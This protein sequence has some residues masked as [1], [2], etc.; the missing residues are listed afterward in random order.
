MLVSGSMLVGVGGVVVVNG[1]VGVLVGVSVSAGVLVAVG[2]GGEVSAGVSVTDVGVDV[3][4]GA[5]G[6]SSITPGVFSVLQKKLVKNIVTR[7]S[8]R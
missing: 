5:G 8:G 6:V 7:L 1:A 3:L 4:I 2:V